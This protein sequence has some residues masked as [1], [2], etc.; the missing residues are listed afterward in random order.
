MVTTPCIDA[1]R[2]WQL[3]CYQLPALISEGTAI[4]VS[5]L[6]ALMKNQVDAVRACSERPA[7]A[8][9][10]NFVPSHV[11]NWS[12]C[13]KTYYQVRQRCSMWHLESLSRQDNIDL[14]QQVPISFMR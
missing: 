12:K 9:F 7:I 4:I 2:W 6:I 13:T 5:P 11:A 1:Y 10:M 8:H 3:L 14:L